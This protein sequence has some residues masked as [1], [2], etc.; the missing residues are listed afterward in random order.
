MKKIPLTNSSEFALVSDRVYKKVIEY[1]WYALRRNALKKNK[2]TGVNSVEH[3]HILLSH[4]IKGK[5]PKG[6]EWDHEDRNPLNNRDGNL[7]LATKSQN[8]A[9]TCTRVTN[10]S[11]FRG[12]SWR[13]GRW[14]VQITVNRKKKHLGYFTS[15]VKAARVY[16]KAA[17]EAFGEFATLNFK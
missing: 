9:N 15:L 11:G 10:K 8:R 13:F 16:D 3:P 5:P 4:L 14:V 6:K 12:V 1:R 2:I 17:L 7:R